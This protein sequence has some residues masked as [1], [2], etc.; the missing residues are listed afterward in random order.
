MHYDLCVIGG[1]IVGLATARALL[2]AGL[3]AI[4]AVH[5]WCVWLGAGAFVV[6]AAG[7][8]DLERTWATKLNRTRPSVTAA[9]RLARGVR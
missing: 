1:G 6:L 3:V 2:A 4:T 7:R 8:P 9:E 5:A